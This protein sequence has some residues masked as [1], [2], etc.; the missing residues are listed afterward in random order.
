[1]TNIRKMAICIMVDGGGIMGYM[2]AFG[3]ETLQLPIVLYRSTSVVT[4]VNLENGPIK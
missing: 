1:M 3:I 2:S 4:P